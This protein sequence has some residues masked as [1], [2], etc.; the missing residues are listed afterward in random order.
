MT[1]LDQYPLKCAILGQVMHCHNY[2]LILARLLH[3]HR[4]KETYL[5]SFYLETIVLLIMID[6]NKIIA[7]YAEILSF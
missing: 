4:W 2:T 1:W 7:I 6:K 3:V 5:P